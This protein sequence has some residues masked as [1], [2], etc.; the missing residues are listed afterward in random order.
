M[1][2]LSDGIQ[3]NWGAALRAAERIVKL[4][5][6]TG[7]TAPEDLQRHRDQ[8]KE[9]CVQLNKLTAALLITPPPTAPKDN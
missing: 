1:T 7:Y 2:K 5:R 3:L 8:I 6:D 4:C 9:V